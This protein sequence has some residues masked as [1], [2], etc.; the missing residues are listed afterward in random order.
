MESNLE[1][2]IKLARDQRFR[3]LKNA[4]DTIDAFADPSLDPET[5]D[6]YES[7]K[8]ELLE[9]YRSTDEMLTDKNDN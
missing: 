2:K 3:S 1:S 5:F 6:K 9:V 8:W 4:F 7:A